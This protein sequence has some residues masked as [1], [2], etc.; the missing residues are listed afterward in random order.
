MSNVSPVTES[1]NTLVL[2]YV[3]TNRNIAVN[4]SFLWLLLCND[5]RFSFAWKDVF[6]WRSRKSCNCWVNTV[7][8]KHGGVV[9]E[10][11]NWKRG[12]EPVG[13]PEW[14]LKMDFSPDKS[15][16]A[17]AGLWLPWCWWWM[18][19]VV[20]VLGTVFMC[21]VAKTD[22]WDTSALP[23]SGRSQCPHA[24]DCLWG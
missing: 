15:A 7:E 5:R 2:H 11:Q 4:V 19:N 20:C 24:L 1:T 6:H 23:C 18:W 13:F 17:E 14:A 10:K 22:E 3:N 21:S 16:W 12:V 8:G 9:P